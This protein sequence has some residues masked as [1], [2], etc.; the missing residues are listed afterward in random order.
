VNYVFNEPGEEK[1]GMGEG[2]NG[3]KL[4]KRRKIHHRGR[5][6][7]RSNKEFTRKGVSQRFRRHG[8]HRGGG[9]EPRARAP[10]SI[11]KSPKR[12]KTGKTSEGPCWGRK[13][14]WV[15]MVN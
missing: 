7:E 4:S 3:A 8:R 1:K 14:D 10:A 11:E 9:K 2:R 15:V 6:K 5:K 13:K 12:Q